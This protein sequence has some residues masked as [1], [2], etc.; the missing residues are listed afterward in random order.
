MYFKLITPLPRKL[1]LAF[2]GGVDSVAAADWLSRSHDLTLAYF[3]HGTEH[4]EHALSWVQNFA[5]ER[6]IPLVV[7]YLVG[8]R[9]P[10]HSLEEHWREHRYAFLYKFQPTTVITAHHLDDVMETYIWSALHGNPRT[11]PLKRDNIL[12]PFLTTPK[13]NFIDWCRDKKLNWCEDASNSDTQY[14]RNYI[15]HS[16]MPHALRVNPGLATTVRKLVMKQ[17]HSGT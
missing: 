13:Q 12:R 7:E 9:N 5:R 4:S 8:T 3:H 15:R 2:S 10:E 11:I 14:T 6:N 1:V 16:L 17:L